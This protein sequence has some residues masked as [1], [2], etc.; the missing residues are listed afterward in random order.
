MRREARRAGRRLAV[1]AA[2]AAALGSS[3]GAALRP[4]PAERGAAAAPQLILLDDPALSHAER[5]G[6]GWP[7][8]SG[9][10]DA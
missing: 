10:Q 7:A 5:A 1:G 6:G 4:G 8:R 9:A 2:I 3:A